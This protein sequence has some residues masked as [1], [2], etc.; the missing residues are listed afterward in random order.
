MIR[1][2]LFPACLVGLALAAIG[3]RESDR[4]G[5][6]QRLPP[7]LVRPPSPQQPR[8]E[9]SPRPEPPPLTAERPRSLRGVRIV[10]D[11]GHGGKDPG[12]RGVS[13]VS[14]KHIVLAI[15]NEL[16]R[17][18]GAQG[19][20]VTST[21]T[22]DR[23]LELD[24]RAAIAERN[25]VDLF[26]SIHADAAQR[27]A[28]SGATVYISRSASSAS[29]RAA[30]RIDAALKRAGI[31]SR[32]IQRADFRV[33]VGHSRPAV[34]VECGYLTNAGDARRLNTPSYR[35]RVAAAIAAGI[36]SFAAR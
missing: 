25:R 15:A 2:L 4:G 33:L 29:L 3:C 30:M 36:S 10:V 6:I 7:P 24:D 19:A 8:V 28:A 21:R 17:I 32:G 27:A 31:E 1:R 11:A 12:T 35:S 13:A 16:S 5:V 20:A 9:P 14:E 34:L 26:V 23:F 18:L 22:T